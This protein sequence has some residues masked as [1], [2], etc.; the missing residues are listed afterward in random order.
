VSSLID[1]GIS[2]YK[3]EGSLTLVQKAL[4][5]VYRDTFYKTLHIWGY[6]SLELDNQ[7]IKFSAPSPTMVKRNRMRFDSEKPELSDFMSELRADDIVYDIGANTGLYSLFAADRCPDGKVIAFEPYP[8]NINLLKQ[9]IDRN[10]LQNIEVVEVALSDSVG[11]VEFS[12]PETDD[13]G[14]G[15]S[16]IEADETESSIEVP[17][18][19][20]DQLIA[21]G[22]IPPPDVVKIDVEGA[23]QLVLEG[24]EDTLAA[25][26]CRT[27]YCEVHLSGSKI[28]PSVEDF[29]GSLEEICGQLR[30]VGYQ[31]QNIGARSDTEVF[32]KAQK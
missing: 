28:R 4:R 18:T 25:E 19:T 20:G 3:E 9:D 7:S 11:T 22:E 31:V 14:Y 30:E 5:K 29:G 15:S 21:D 23:E 10:Q 13:V 24:L 32:L 16:S 26:D 12:Q 27:V 8:P 2:I 17:T 6:Y 1:R